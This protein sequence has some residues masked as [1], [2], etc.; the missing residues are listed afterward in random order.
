MAQYA[1][2][3]DLQPSGPAHYQAFLRRLA[4][5]SAWVNAQAIANMSG[6]SPRHHPAGAEI[7]ERTIENPAP[8]VETPARRRHLYTLAFG[9]PCSGGAAGVKRCLRAALPAGVRRPTACTALQPVRFL[10][11]EYLPHAVR[12]AVSGVA[13]GAAWYA[14]G[15]AKAPIP[16]L[17][18]P[19][20]TA[21]AWPK[22]R[23]RAEVRIQQQLG[24]AAI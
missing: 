8:L 12:K 13:Q 10:Q 2:G 3:Q 9:V 16:R 4:S 19:P 15:C 24:S 18:L 22:S 11:Y 14:F 21:S 5:S 1:T 17:T 23:I 7:V 20:S 6:H